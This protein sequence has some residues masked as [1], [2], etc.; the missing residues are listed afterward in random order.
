[1]ATVKRADLFAGQI[2][3]LKEFIAALELSDRKFRL[4][5]IRLRIVFV[6]ESLL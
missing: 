5:E 1:M 3:A 6:G 2:L 4:E